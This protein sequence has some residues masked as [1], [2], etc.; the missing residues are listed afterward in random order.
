MSEPVGLNARSGCVKQL[1]TAVQAGAPA[2]V[3]GG[4]SW[5]G[6]RTNP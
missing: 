4:V 1:L 2:A 5:R 6:E 3:K